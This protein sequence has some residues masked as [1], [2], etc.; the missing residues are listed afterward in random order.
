MWTGAGPR[1][2]RQRA[3]NATTPQAA[4]CVPPPFTTPAIIC[5]R[6]PACTPD[7]MPMVRSAPPARRLPG[8]PARLP[9]P[10]R[11][12]NPRTP[13]CAADSAR[14]RPVRPRCPMCAASRAGASSRQQAYHLPFHRPVELSCS[15]PMLSSVP[16]FW[17]K[18]AAA[19]SPPRAPPPRPAPPWR[20][21][22][23]V[24]AKPPAAQRP[25]RRS[26]RRSVPGSPRLARRGPGGRC[27]CV[28]RRPSVRR[29]ARGAGV[30]RAGWCAGCRSASSGRWCSFSVDSGRSCPGCGTSGG[31]RAGLRSRGGTG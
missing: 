7:P 26:R 24:A 5:P 2:Y 8:R 29:W 12:P 27:G 23:T 1:R 21:L 22:P 11:A 19:A 9:G 31:S 30:M 6:A 25:Y 3:A 20:P 17:R 15:M 16:W 14:R 28:A 13:C 18:P 10:G 4:G